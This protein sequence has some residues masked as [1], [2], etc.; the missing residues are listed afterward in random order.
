MAVKVK[1]RDILQHIAAYPLGKSLEE[2]QLELGIPT[3][4][5]MSEIEN[6]FG[7]SPK[8][9]EQL[10][11]KLDHLFNYPDGSAR[12]LSEKLGSF[13]GVGQSQLFIGNGSDEI[14]RLLLRAFLNS[15]EEA[16]MAE[17]TFPR[18]KTNVTI[19][20][21]KPVIVPLK[22]GVHDLDAML[23]HITEQTKMIFVCNPNNPTG[24][25]VEK[26]SLQG[27]IEKVPDHILIILDEAY[28]E[29][30]T[31]NEYLQSIP[32]LTEHSNLVILRTFSKVYGLAGLR[33]GYGIMDSFITSELTKVKEVFNVNQLA[34]AAAVIA[35]EDQEF[36][37]QCI[38][39]NEEGR[40][41]LEKELATL[42][43][44][45][46][47]TQANFMMVHT[48]RDGNEVAQELLMQGIMVKSAVGLGY[49]ESIRVTISSMEDN[50]NFIEALK[51]LDMSR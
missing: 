49:K 24:T 50:R 20:G 17:I 34:Q 10:M 37:K 1:S 4:R 15:G 43:Y 23:A 40:S 13:L 30:A 41:Y 38:F 33:I 19:E 29:Y 27:F 45:F 39:H 3:L 47:P 42:G 22:N 25:I 12:C 2:I 36:R 5:N 21:G 7:C 11:Q 14:I 44:S 26:E 48:G 6:V 28:Y 31:S 46:F 35:I 9:K 16:I 51:N 8:V 18:Y 32:L